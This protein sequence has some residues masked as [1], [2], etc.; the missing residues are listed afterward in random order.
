MILLTEQYTYSQNRIILA[1]NQFN[2]II[3]LDHPRKG[4]TNIIDSSFLDFL[5]RI[6]FSFLNYFICDQTFCKQNKSIE[7]CIYRNKD[8]KKKLWTA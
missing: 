7:I 4:S 6:Q 2:Y 8:N 1:L 5:E 3:F